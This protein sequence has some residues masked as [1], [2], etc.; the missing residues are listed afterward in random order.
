M[1]RGPRLD[2]PAALHHVIVR[3]IE[4]RTIFR[5]DHDRRDF[6]KRLARLVSQ[7]HSEL[8][9]WALMP[10]HAH[11]LLRTHDLPLSR[12]MQR[13]LTGYVRAFNLVRYIHLNPV[14]SALPVTADSLERYQWTGHAVLLGRRKFR[15]QNT[16]LVLSQFGRTIREARRA[17][18]HFILEGLTGC[19][20]DLNGG[21]LRRSAGGWELV[22][23]L[24]RGRE[25]WAYDE[26]V[27]GSSE[28]VREALNQLTPEQPLRPIASDVSAL[29][30]ELSLRSARHVGLS[31]A[32]ITGQTRRHD[33]IRARTLVCQIAVRQH[34]LSLAEIARHLNV[35]PRSVSRALQRP[36]VLPSDH[37]LQSTPAL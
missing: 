2:Y 11:L 19:L 3:G 12:L 18:R 4:R 32:E 17:Y 5:S 14:R 10:N 9:A 22:P 31:I 20:P 37:P 24:R 6:L 26:R 25:R 23:K 15:A 1:P 29:L 27:L 34:G 13:L 33:V 16:D 30:D 8:Y 35:S 28:F 36:S 7:S 21:G